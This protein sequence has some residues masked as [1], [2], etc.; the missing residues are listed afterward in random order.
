MGALMASGRA[1]AIEMT[2][3]D[4]VT[5][6]GTLE[7]QRVT[8]GEAVLSDDGTRINTQKL[9]LSV[10]ATGDRLIHASAPEGVVIVGG[11]EKKAPSNR[12]RRLG[13]QEIMKYGSDFADNAGPGDILLDG[14]GEGAVAT[15]GEDG[16]IRAD[17]LIWSDR[18]SRFLLPGNFKQ[19]GSM[20]VDTSMRVTGAA[21]TVDQDFRN[22]TYYSDKK[23]P[24]EIVW[25][26]RADSPT[27]KKDGTSK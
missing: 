25:E 1:W 5:T 8:A 23:T 7:V 9:S 3:V 4:L 10:R 19:Q 17:Q 6:S 21:V 13:L 11:E 26:R 15:L 27:T 2:S 22:W 20:G 12:S 18:L 14:K 16:E 24:A